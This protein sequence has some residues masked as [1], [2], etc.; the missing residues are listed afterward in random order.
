VLM[1]VLAFG[2]I[3]GRLGN[4]M[5]GTDTGGRL[6]DWAIGFT[7]PPPGT[8]TL[9]EFGRVVFGQPLWTGAPPACQALIPAGQPCTVHLTQL[10]GALVGVLLVG[11]IIWALRHARSHGGVMLHAVIW[12]SLLRSVIEEPFRDN[13]LYWP[14]YVDA[15]AG[16]GL[17]TATQLASV[18]IVLVALYLLL[19]RPAKEEDVPKVTRSAR[20]ARPAGRP[21]AR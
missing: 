16:I 21:K 10:Y 15:S 8:P 3:G 5:N 7:W 19:V 18:P 4:F 6:T 1:P 9:G 11:V 17:L 12:Y 20:R 2:I 14:I 13:P